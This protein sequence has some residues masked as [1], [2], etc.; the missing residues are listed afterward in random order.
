MDVTA[1]NFLK[2]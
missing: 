1:V 2:D